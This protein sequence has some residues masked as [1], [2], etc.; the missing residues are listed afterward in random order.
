MPFHVSKRMRTLR[1]AVNYL[2]KNNRTFEAAKM[3][4]RLGFVFLMGTQGTVQIPVLGW[5]QDVSPSS[6]EKCLLKI[7]LTANNYHW[8]HEYI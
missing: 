8:I 1:D 4:S 6:E 2:H 7:P 3:L 5:F